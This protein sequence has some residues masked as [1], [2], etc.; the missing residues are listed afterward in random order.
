MKGRLALGLL[1]FLALAEPSVRVSEVTRFGDMDCFEVRT[2][3]ATYVYGKRGAGFAQLLD[4]DGRDWISYRH[5]DLSAG[6]YRGLPKCGQPVKYFHCGYGFGPYA[7]ANPFV[8][9]AEAVGPGHVRIRSVTTQ[10]DAAGTWDFFA[11]HATFTLERIP[12]GRYWFLYEGT[13]GGT[14]ET[15]GDFV[16]RPRGHRTPLT[17]PWDEV[18]PWVVFGAAESPHRLLLVNHQTDSPVD[19]YVSWPYRPTLREP[20]PIMTV[21]GFGRPAWDDANQHVPALTR[22][23]ARFSLAF[24]RDDAESTIAAARAAMAQP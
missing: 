13:P 9:T 3:A 24:L 20:T 11:T 1:P 19:S 6:E 12:G 23:P 10:G 2:P 15:A 22:L 16:L 8:S 17:R 14:L 5:G 7:T 18:V 4:A 21:F